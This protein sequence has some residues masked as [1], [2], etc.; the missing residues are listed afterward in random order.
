MKTRP[1]IF[2]MRL[3]VLSDLHMEFSAF[4]LP[5]TDADVV[6]LAGDVDLGTEGLEWIKYSLRDCPDKP[7]IYVI[8]NHEYYRHALPEL[9]ETLRRESAGTHIHLLENSAVALNGWTFLGCTLWTSFLSGPDPEAHMRFAENM[10]NDYR[11][12][13]NSAERRPLRARDTARLHQESV[14]WLK[15][16][17][18]QHDPARTI[19]VTHHS[20]SFRS[21]SPQYLNG[22]LAP[23][24]SSDLDALIEASGIPLWIHGHTHHNV[25]Y[26][27]GATRV[28]SNQ[29]GYPGSICQGFDRGLVVEVK[30]TDI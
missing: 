27:I 12:I 22:P 20:P 13:I 17:L 19:V 4:N 3:H 26:R 1:E 8:G 11:S 14:A 28:L 29:R 21:E 7:V 30:H 18:T 10:M 24:F 9:T 5:V 2:N 23:A 15:H 25:D 16:E 6:V